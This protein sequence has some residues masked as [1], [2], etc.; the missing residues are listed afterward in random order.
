MSEALAVQMKDFRLWW[1]LKRYSQA[2][3]N[4]MR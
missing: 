2:K 4:M 1:C 3:L